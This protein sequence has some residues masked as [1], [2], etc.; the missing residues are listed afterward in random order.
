[1]E[2]NY[3]ARTTLG[4]VRTGTV[5]AANEQVAIEA[6]N[7]RNFT[8]I[9]IEPAGKGMSFEISFLNR[10][11]RK[12]LVVFSR[13]LAT[14]VEAKVPLVEALNTLSAQTTNKYFKDI[15]YEV[16]NDVNGGTAFSLALAKYPKGF[17]EFY[18]SMIESGEISGNLQNTLT[19]LADYLENNY[20]LM[21]KIKG[22]MM[23]PAFIVFTLLVVGTLMLVFVIPQLTSM[24][25][26]SGQELPV[27]TKMLVAVSDLM[28][29][30]WWLIIPGIFG[31][32]IGIYLLVKRTKKG[33]VVWDSVIIRTPG[34]RGIL[35]NIYITRFA[36]NF[37]TLVSAGIPIVKAL[38]I[39]GNIVGNTE[40]KVLIYRVADKVGTGENISSVF[41]K[42]KLI[43]PIVNSILS[44]GEKTG[45]LDSV[46][47]NISRFYKREVDAV[48]GNITKLIEPIMMI[49]MG[50]A[51]AI[52]VAA[53]LMPIYNMTQAV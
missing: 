50:I 10:V 17:S 35:M 46:L 40:Y 45:K 22:A 41:A 3:Q 52:L 44:I 39:T 11:K 8:I 53:I 6:L 18:I 24:L 2:F 31:S 43:P 49:V 4:E 26:E 32:V 7:R 20:D 28:I 51:V 15:I 47:K 34:I 21:R 25:I 1:M 13:Q 36:E 30:F 5:D 14:L 37:S 19:Y 29:A 48:V 16:A 42:S 23:Y 38:K 9:S 27:A 12:D 33:K